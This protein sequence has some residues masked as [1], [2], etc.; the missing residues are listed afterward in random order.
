MTEYVSPLIDGLSKL[1]ESPGYAALQSLYEAEEKIL[2]RDLANAVDDKDLRIIQGRCKMIK[3][4]K[5]LPETTVDKY[6]Q[7]QKATK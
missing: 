6:I 7:S 1:I 2:L 3:K 4:F 5:D